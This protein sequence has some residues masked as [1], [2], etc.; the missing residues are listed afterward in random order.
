MVGACCLASTTEITAQH[1]TIN[2]AQST[3]VRAYQSATTQASRQSWRKPKFRRAFTP[4]LSKRTKKSKPG[5]PSIQKY[6]TT[7]TYLV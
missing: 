3:Q 2:P 6:T 4:H 5:R 1:S 7:H